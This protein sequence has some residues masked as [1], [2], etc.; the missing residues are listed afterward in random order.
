[1]SDYLKST[2]FATKDALP[3]GNAGK[4]VKGTEIDNEFNNIADAIESKADLLNP[5]FSGLLT[6]DTLTTGGATNIG[7]TL[8][9]AGALSAAADIQFTGTGRVKVPTG[10]TAQRPASPS[11][12]SLRF[13]TTLGFLENYTGTEWRLVSPDPTPAQVSDQVNTSTGYFQVPR[14]SIAQRPASPVEGL[15]RYNSESDIYEG[16][17]NGSWHKFLTVDQG[18]YTITY[19]AVGG[20]AGGGP[21][22]VRAG[23]GGGGAGRVTAST[24]SVT[25]GASVLTITIGG[26]GAT[27]TAGT[28]STITGIVSATGGSVGNLNGG[29]SGNGFSGGT[30]TTTPESAIGIGGGGGGAGAVGANGVA[31]SGD[32]GNGGNGGAGVETLIT[33]TSQYFGGGGGGAGYAA[34][35]GTGGT[36]GG[37]N[38]G[39]TGPS[40]AGSPNT[41]GGGGSRVA[42]AGSSGGSGVIFLSMPTLNYTG[43]HT[44]SPTITTTGSNTV[45]KFTG[46]G[47]YTC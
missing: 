38:G 16:Y 35:G 15:V 30:G 28:A 17:I 9:V 43:T 25:P 22:D 6:T 3:T 45:L 24:T 26:G 36:G 8:A 13:N 21:V 42:V 23:S 1:M 41:G 18:S 29:T 7:G 5:V 46:S 44:G 47:T 33:G 10:T 32:V 20:G 39:G 14:G 34:A 40:T 31:Y 27:N 4:I 11:A 12:G 19:L 2:N 37:G